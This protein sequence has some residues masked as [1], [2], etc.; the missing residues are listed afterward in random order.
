[1]NAT[2]ILAITLALAITT[3]VA[4]SRWRSREAY[5]PLALTPTAPAPSVATERYSIYGWR[6]DRGVTHY[7]ND[8]TEVPDAYRERV[9]TLIKDWAAPESPPE[10]PQ[11]Q[12][13][14]QARNTTELTPA[15]RDVTRPSSLETKPS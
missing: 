7:T 3:S 6:D 13:S 11:P 14:S 1:M 12:T 5:A 9:T 15:A 2:R 8:L 10:P 4:C